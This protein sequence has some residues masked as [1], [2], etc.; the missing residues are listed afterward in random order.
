MGEG[1]PHLGPTVTKNL[2]MPLLL[3]PDDE[4]EWRPLAQEDVI[5]ITFTFLMVEW[6]SLRDISKDRI[7]CS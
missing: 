5:W 2:A 1:V 7:G 3:R 6:C 4:D